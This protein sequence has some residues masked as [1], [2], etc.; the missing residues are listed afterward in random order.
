M[1]WIIV[2]LSLI[3]TALSSSQS[4]HEVQRGRSSV[5]EVELSSDVTKLKEKDHGVYPARCD[6]EQG[7][8][9]HR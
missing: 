7:S 1:F 6:R 9:E 4:R 8:G 3:S 5:Q 2:A